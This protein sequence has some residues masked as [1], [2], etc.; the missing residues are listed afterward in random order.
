M[1]KKKAKKIKSERVFQVSLTVRF[2]MTSSLLMTHWKK[3]T[4]ISNR[5]NRCILTPTW[6]KR[7]CPL[8]SPTGTTQSEPLFVFHISGR[9]KGGGGSWGGLRPAL[10]IRRQ[11]QCRGQLLVHDNRFHCFCSLS[12]ANLPSVDLW[13]GGCIRTLGVWGEDGEGEA[14]RSRPAVGFFFAEESRG[15]SVI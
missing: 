2:V 8:G 1:E 12:A 15:S 14:L 13:G 3:Y 4:N 9:K 5:S 7:C 10:S 11:H 6:V